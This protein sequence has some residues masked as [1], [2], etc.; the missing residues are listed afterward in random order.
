MSAPSTHPTTVISFQLKAIG[1]ISLMILAVGT[2]LSWYF[3]SRG[4][5]VVKEELQKRTLALTQNLAYNSRYGILTEDQVILQQLIESIMQ[6]DQIIFAMIADAEGKALA[7]QFKGQPSNDSPAAFQAQSH[8]AY[9]APHITTLAVHYHA[10]GEQDIYANAGIYH[11]VAPVILVDTS[12]TSDQEQQLADA[13]SFM[14]EQPNTIPDA[15]P[16]GSVQVILSLDKMEQGIEQVFITGIGL[17]LITILIGVLISFLF[18]RYTLTP[19]KAMVNATSQIASGDLSQ[20]VSVRSSDEIGV[21]GTAFNRMTESLNQMT[22]AQEQ[23]LTELSAANHEIEALN[24]GLEQKVTDRTTELR[25]AKDIAEEANRAKSIF[26]ANMSHE[27]RTPLNAILGY[28]Q[29]LERDQ[30]MDEQQNKAVKTIGTSGEH[31]L[32]LINEILD[33]SKIEAG[34]EQLNLANFDLQKTIDG[35]DRMFQLRCGQKELSWEIETDTFDHLLH[36][37]EGKLR[38]VLINLHPNARNGRR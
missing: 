2:L 20:R 15:S 11:A 22:A 32:A 34:H 37:D 1:F 35:L 36:G 24:Q 16:V 10:V 26:L 13:L 29:I 8:A 14:S 17:T 28:A 19:I 12:P 9:L 27:I 21:L 25:E 18:V 6:E 4:E 5:V 23:R 30:N 7:Q 31:L 3:L 33:I 38:Q